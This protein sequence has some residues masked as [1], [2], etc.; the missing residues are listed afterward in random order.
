MRERDKQGQTELSQ[1]FK[2]GNQASMTLK[3]LVQGE[4]ASKFRAIVQASSV[5]TL[6]VHAAVIHIADRV[7]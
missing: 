6:P 7:M 1:V 2:R 3:W 5:P 4:R